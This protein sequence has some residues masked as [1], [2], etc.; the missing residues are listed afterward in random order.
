MNK[1]EHAERYL[2]VPDIADLIKQQKE[3]IMDIIE[4]F[5]KRTGYITMLGALLSVGEE[6]D[7]SYS[8]KLQF[9]IRCESP[10]NDQFDL[11]HWRQF[12]VNG[13]WVG[14]VY[15]MEKQISALCW[16][17]FSSRLDEILAIV[18]GK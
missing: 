6:V 4:L 5:F 3:A 14:N 13:D 9:H 11:K 7:V 16:E 17:D 18:G 15:G 12:Y 8:K 1:I 2:P 10:N